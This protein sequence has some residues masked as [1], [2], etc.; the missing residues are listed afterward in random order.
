[1]ARARFDFP[2]ELAAILECR[3]AVDPT[4]DQ[5]VF[6]GETACYLLGS[7]ATAAADVLL[8]VVPAVA[9]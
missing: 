4:P 9:P 2:Q 6:D 5:F 7:M 3:L 1:M 8:V